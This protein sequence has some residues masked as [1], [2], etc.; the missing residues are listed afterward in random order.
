MRLGL[1]GL[2]S[3]VAL[4]GG[5]AAPAQE[6]MDQGVLQTQ[7][8][9]DRLGF[10][11]GVVDGK[12]GQSL[13]LALKGFQSARGLSETGKIDD[14]TR[15]ALAPYA[16]VR[17]TR[18]FTVRAEDLRGP[19]I[20][21]LPEKA[22]DQAKLRH[23]GY[24]NALERIAERFHTT[25][26]AIV[27][28]NP[29]G[30]VLGAGAKLVL[31]NIVP[32]SRDYSASIS[33]E[34]RTTLSSFN[35]DARQPKADHIVVDKSESALKVY[36]KAGKLVAQFPV[37]TGSRYDP[38]PIGSWTIK[39][40]SYNPPFHYNP[41]LFWDVSNSK[42]KLVLPPG[43][44]GPVGV[45]WMDLNKPHYGIHGTPHPETIGRAESHGC[46]RLS[47]WDAARLSMMISPGTKARFQA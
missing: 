39:G 38:L 44:N 16:Q 17:A 11:P 9:L 43:P 8:V 45:I 30:T 35:L 25:P 29:P 7:V 2:V 1:L 34:W 36:D 28:M 31:P 3:A 33:A 26:D 21:R 27:A 42:E 24:V 6:T 46:I 12:G 32:A 47:N 37:T 19:F 20:G 13:T 5:V 41:K 15:R 22:E 4:A 10:A 40:S 18:T 14:A 23:L